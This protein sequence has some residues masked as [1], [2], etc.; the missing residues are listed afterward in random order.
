MILHTITLEG[1]DRNLAV[2]IQTKPAADLIDNRTNYTTVQNI[3]LNTQTYDGGHAFGTNASYT[4]LKYANILSGHQPGH[5][6]LYY[7]GPPTAR[8]KAPIYSQGNTLENVVDSEQICDDGISWSFQQNSK[9]SNV[10]ET[11]SRLALFIDNGVTISNYTF[12]PGPYQLANCKTDITGF[13]ITPPSENITINN[14]TSYS[15][16]GKL[17]ASTKGRYSS[18]ITINHEQ[19]LKPGYDIA[20]GDVKNMTINNSNFQNNL[21]LINGHTENIAISNSQIS[22]IKPYPFP[23]DYNVSCQNVTPFNCQ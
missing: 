13:W 19:M 6:A 3:T 16:G 11:G 22:N 18:N 17:T 4:T 21:V 9:I 7:A 8:V 15:M 20:I 12:Y 23:S 14:F 5:F 10:V 2:L 1:E